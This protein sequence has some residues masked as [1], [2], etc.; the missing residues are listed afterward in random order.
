MRSR[1][2]ILVALIWALPAPAFAARHPNRAR[3]HAFAS[4]ARLVGY[5]RKH[6]ARTRG[7]AENVPSP[8]SEPSAPPAVRSAPKAAA[9]TGTGPAS[10]GSAS[11]STTNNQEPGVDEPDIVKTDGST[12]FAVEAGTLYAVATQPALH[13]AGSLPL[14]NAGDAAQLLI[15]GDRL[16]V[17]SGG[18]GPVA[19]AGPV[20]G[21]PTR[22]AS[23]PATSQ[24]PV[25]AAR[26]LRLRSSTTTVTEVDVGDPATM[27][28]AR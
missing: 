3:P 7:L 25:K 9:P 16:L 8:L 27:R 4:C 11:F 24:T 1:V 28:V 15:R 20:R 19:F 22:T 26:A 18:A 6:F 13:L 10:G 2:A 23:G 12:I 5:A 17:V 21:V 14:G